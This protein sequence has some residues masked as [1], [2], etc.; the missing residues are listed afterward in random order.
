MYDM[1][2]EY[3]YLAINFEHFKK[4]DNWI[5]ITTPIAVTLMLI[6]SYC[7][8]WT[9]VLM[10]FCILFQI[11][12]IIYNFLPYSKYSEKISEMQMILGDI[13]SE[14]EKDWKESINKSEDE[15]LALE[16]YTKYKTKYENKKSQYFSNEYLKRNDKYN[17][18]ACKEAMN[19]F[20]T[21]I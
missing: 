3:F 16:L 10:P 1:K 13:F 14:M 15:E 19:Y 17:T 12:S 6:I 4:I 2:Y 9:N 21:L 11:V 18:Y 5:I 7:P 8:Q 20:N